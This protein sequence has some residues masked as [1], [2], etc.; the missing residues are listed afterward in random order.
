LQA[1]NKAL[2]NIPAQAKR[3]ARLQARRR[4]AGEPLKRTM[5][6]RPGLPPGYRKEMTDI[7]DEILYEFHRLAMREPRP[8]ERMRS[9]I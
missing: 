4:A 3:L 9:T 1:F 6:L 8:P 5:P 2:E 7:V